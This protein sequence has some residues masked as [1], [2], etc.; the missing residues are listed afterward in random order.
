M[1]ED[2][3]QLLIISEQFAVDFFVFCNAY[4]LHVDLIL[5]Y[6][7]HLK[8]AIDLDNE[9]NDR[10]EKGLFMNDV[11]NLL[12]VGGLF[13]S[14]SVLTSLIADTSDSINNTVRF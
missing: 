5:F 9:C 14:M 13:M 4:W 8:D 10:T 2:S 3:W 7:C 1:W 12:C 11:M 6:Q